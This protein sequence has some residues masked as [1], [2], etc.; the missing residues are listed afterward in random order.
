ME[1]YV[2]RDLGRL[3]QLFSFCDK[4]HLSKDSHG[5]LK[6]LTQDALI[7]LSLKNEFRRPAEKDSYEKMTI[8]FD[9]EVI[10]I[11]FFNKE[12]IDDIVELDHVSVINA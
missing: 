8:A 3:S 1:K 10:A 2:S 5:S 9:D 12:E 11:G 6:D 4:H 7:T